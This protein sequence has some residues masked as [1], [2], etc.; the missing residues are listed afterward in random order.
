MPDLH[1][2]ALLN[3]DC[4]NRYH[5]FRPFFHIVVYTK[6]AGAKFPRSNWIGAQWLAMSVLIVSC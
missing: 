2:I 3:L 6:I 1:A 5:S 4:A